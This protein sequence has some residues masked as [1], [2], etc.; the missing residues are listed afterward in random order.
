MSSRALTGWS[1]FA[2]IWLV[3]AGAFN[4]VSGL[5][6]I[7]KSSYFT[8]D[9]LVSHVSTWGW[10]VLIVGVV[11]LVAGFMVF[12]ANPTGHEL[13][14]VAA[15]FSAFIW[16]FFLFAAPIGALMGLIVNGLVIYGLTIGSEPSS[17]R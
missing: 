9:M 16:F 1:M 5:T 4:A 2:S 6:A 14:V 3:V 7:H 10:I 12:G 8:D 13:G 11:Q 17:E 15:M